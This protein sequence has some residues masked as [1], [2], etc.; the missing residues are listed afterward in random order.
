MRGVLIFFMLYFVF[1]NKKTAKECSTR[2]NEWATLVP[3]RRRARYTSRWLN[4]F[5]RLITRCAA[6]SK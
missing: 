1:F 4:L 3:L 6:K 5:N 2:P